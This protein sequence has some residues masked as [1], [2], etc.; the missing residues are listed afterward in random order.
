MSATNAAAG[1]KASQGGEPLPDLN[2]PPAPDGYE[3]RLQTMMRDTAGMY[4]DLA[5]NYRHEVAI[6]KTYRIVKK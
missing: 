4:V 5:G 1:Y 2:L 3:W 6:R